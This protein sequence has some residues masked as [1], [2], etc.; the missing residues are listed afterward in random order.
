MVEILDILY[1]LLEG[2]Q[3]LLFVYRIVVRSFFIPFNLLKTLS[4]APF[5]THS[6]TTA[7]S[8]VAVCFTSRDRQWWQYGATSDSITDHFSHLRH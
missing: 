8:T 3:D 4:S 2:N 5:K 1:T 6:M 7:G